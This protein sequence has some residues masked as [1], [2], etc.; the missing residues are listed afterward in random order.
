MSALVIL[1]PFV[2]ALVGMLFVRRIPPGLIA[3][4]GTAL[5]AV[6]AI[7]VAFAGPFETAALLTPTGTI[8]ITLGVRVDGLS[9]T[10]AV[11]VP[12]VALAIQIYAIGYMRHDV[13]YPS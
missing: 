1:C 6:F 4:A 12:L 10:V 5:S 2:G 3:V 11:M 13:R 9:G 8:P 7:L